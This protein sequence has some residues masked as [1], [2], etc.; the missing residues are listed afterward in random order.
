MESDQFAVEIVVMLLSF[1][2]SVWWLS[3]RIGE[4]SD[5][6]V[7]PAGGDPRGAN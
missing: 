7:R 2:G 1:L 3:R 6:I 5:Y 4:K